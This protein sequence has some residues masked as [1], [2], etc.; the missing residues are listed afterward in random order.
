MER[1]AGHQKT[2]SHIPITGLYF[3]G[4]SVFHDDKQTCTSNVSA[5]EHG[6]ETAQMRCLLRLKRWDLVGT[7]TNAE[8]SSDIMLG[9]REPEQEPSVIT[10]GSKENDATEQSRSSWK[11]FPFS[12]FRKSLHYRYLASHVK[13]WR[14]TSRTAFW[15]SDHINWRGLVQLQ[16]VREQWWHN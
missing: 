3:P 11:G 12:M 7:T 8:D 16:Q 13:A 6:S 1:V 9:F 10:S 5:A 4:W 2:N 15:L 14:N